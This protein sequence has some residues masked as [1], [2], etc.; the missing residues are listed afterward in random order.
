MPQMVAH[1]RPPIRSTDQIVEWTRYSSCSVAEDPSQATTRTIVGVQIAPPINVQNANFAGCHPDQPAATYIGNRLPGKHRAAK[2]AI[3]PL[4]SNQAAKGETSRVIPPGNH[5]NL[6]SVAA[7]PS[8]R[9]TFRRWC[10]TY[11]NPKSPTLTD[12]SRPSSG[13]APGSPHQ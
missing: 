1:S 12:S 13:P 3:Q 4:R 7:R 5:Q 8:R 11:H 9:A 6:F 2:I 10:P